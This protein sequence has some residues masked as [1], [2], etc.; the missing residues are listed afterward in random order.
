MVALQQADSDV[1]PGAT[2]VVARAGTDAAPSRIADLDDPVARLQARLA[3]GELSLTYDSLRGYLPALLE[4]LEIPASSQT[5]VF[6]RTSLQTD[7]IAPWT[8]RALYF[9]DEV[10]VGW[11]QE[12]PFLEIASIDPV[13]GAVFYTLSQTDP[14]TARFTRETT[15]CLMC[16]ESRSVTGGVPGLIVRSV[17]VDRLGYP[18]TNVHQGGTNDRTPIEDR[19]GGWYVTGTHGDMAHAGNVYAPD[20]SHEVSDKARYLQAVD[21]AA[22][23]NVDALEDRFYVDAYLT[24][25]SDLVALMVLTHQAQ[26]HNLITLLHE[27]TTEALELE[28]TV[29]RTRGGESE[30]EG[31]MPTTIARVEGPAERLVRALLFVKEAPLDGPVSGTSSFAVDFAARGPWSMEGRSLRELDLETRLFRYPLSF[32]VYTEAFDALPTLAKEVVARRLVAVLS[33]EDRSEVFRHL[34]A[35]DRATTLD[36]LRDTKPELLRMGR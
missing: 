29:T 31:H 26:L 19:W 7:R 32:L 34:N 1:L 35:E 28:A 9:N 10:Y 14:E 12:S 3:T 16:H 5:L 33:G 36:I 15:T 20:L 8:P 21:F 2:T 4:A 18:I 25:H 6:S 27:E 13:A 24:P 22:G 30:G 17:L 11:V 23:G